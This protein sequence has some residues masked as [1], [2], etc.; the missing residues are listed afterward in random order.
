MQKIIRNEVGEYARLCKR[1]LVRGSGGSILIR[2]G[3]YIVFTSHLE[4][5]LS[6]ERGVRRDYR[7]GQ[8]LRNATESLGG[9]VVSMV[10][11]ICSSEGTRLG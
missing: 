8:S 9:R 5:L 6:S 4:H 11:D 7:V 10:L 1:R 2:R 3:Y